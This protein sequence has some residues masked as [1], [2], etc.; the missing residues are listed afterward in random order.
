M[1]PSHAEYLLAA[2]PAL[3]Y[4]A[5]PSHVLFHPSPPEKPEPL[6]AAYQISPEI[7]LKGI[8]ALLKEPDK[9]LRIRCCM[10]IRTIIQAES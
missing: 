3:I 2:L 9:D 1:A 6:L 10:A 8:Q 5:S 4:L 7:V